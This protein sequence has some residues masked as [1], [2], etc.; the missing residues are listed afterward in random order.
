MI[1]PRS[2]LPLMND[3]DNRPNIFL[4]LF[5]TDIFKILSDELS[6]NYSEISAER[7]EDYC[8]FKIKIVN[9]GP[10]IDQIVKYPNSPTH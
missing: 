8:V 5:I 2:P 9:C 1:K 4:L 10:S 6:Q 7:D 3:T